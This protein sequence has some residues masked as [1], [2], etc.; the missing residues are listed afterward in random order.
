[1]GLIQEKS[2]LLSKEIVILYK[3]LTKEKK[4][5]VL[6]K[7]LLRSGTSVGA[8]A[9]EGGAAQTKKDFVFKMNLSYKEAQETLFWLRLLVETGYLNDTNAGYA[10]KLCDEVCRILC[11]IIKTAND[12]LKEP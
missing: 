8:N 4:E 7:Q 10:V 2:F 3:I 9:S 1:M 11:A 12:N 5:Y 6:S